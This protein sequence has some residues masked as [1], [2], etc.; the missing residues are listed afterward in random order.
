V[1]SDFSPVELD[2]REA[3]AR[4]LAL[5]GTTSATLVACGG[6]KAKTAD[7]VGGAPAPPLAVPP[8]PAP[9][10]APAPV[11]APAPG[12]L[13]AANWLARSTGPGVV[14]A[15]DFSSSNEIAAFA[16]PRQ[17]GV[18]HAGAAIDPFQVA[19]PVVGHAMRIVALGARLTQDFLAS[20]GPGPRSLVIDDATYWPDPATAGNY[21][22]HLCKP[23][24][25][26]RNNLLL[27][28]AR[29]GTT[30]TVT[31]VPSSGQPMQATQRDWVIGD[32]VGHQCATSWARLFSALKADSTG[33]A[34]DDIN[35]A[36][37][38]LR[39]VKDQTRFPHGPQ[40]FGYG[41]YGRPEYQAAFST[42]RPSDYGSNAIDNVLRSNLW[43]G[44]EFYLQWRQ[45]V[46]PR[47][48]ALNTV[49][50]NGDNR[51][52]RK[53][54]M[55]QSEMTVPQQ[56]TGGYGPGATRF[57][58]PSTP[59][60]VFAMAAYS[61]NGGLAGRVLTSNLDGT[62]SFQPGG[63]YEA[64]ARYA[65]GDLNPGDA[66][67]IPSNEWVTFCLHVKPGLRWSGDNPSAAGV[68]NTLVEMKVAREGESTYTTVF[69][70]ANQAIVYGS[71]GPIEDVWSS[72]L[73]GY[74][75]IVLTGYLNIELGSVP[76]QAAYYIDFG[77][78]V[79]S[80]SPIPPPGS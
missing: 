49:A 77:Q 15:H 22:V 25:D 63:P 26:Q 43:D 39:S 67:E 36:G 27:V 52:G 16:P 33:R 1:K 35:N 70:M 42:W 21:Y 24:V 51:Y 23:F 65:V 6:G 38:T 69:A 45:K 9:A 74:N 54:W 66:W 4:L 59:E 10:P 68:Q 8:S 41:W 28:T 55:L 78:V 3:L 17:A 19:D 32:H 71:S 56:I 79:F 40:A 73:P 60:P 47:F 2:R 44:E 58:I 29:S 7:A 62:G 75:A 48:L 50:Y 5:A 34:T 12:P 31:Y 18:L 13:A 80:K 20:G 11:P 72:A 37:T 53:V 76:P 30:L 64:T 57:S 61:F 46:D 14:W